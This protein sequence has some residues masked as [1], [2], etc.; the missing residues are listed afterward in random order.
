MDAKFLQNVFKKDDDATVTQIGGS[1]FVETTM[2]VA[3]PPPPPPLTDDFL[4]EDA[5]TAPRPD[6]RIQLVCNIFIVNSVVTLVWI[7]I[8]LPFFSWG[9]FARIVLIA[10]CVLQLAFYLAFVFMREF[11]QPPV[12]ICIVWLCWVVTM[13]IAFG[14]VTSLLGNVAPLQLEAMLWVQSL[15]VI[16][17][18]KRSPREI[19]APT[20]FLCMCIGTMVVWAVCVAEFVVEHDWTSGTV[21][22]VVAI[23][24]ALYSAHGIRE[25]EVHQY[26]ASWDDLLAA[27]VQFYGEPVIQ[28]LR[29]IRPLNA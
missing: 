26:N 18:T 29:K 27:I 1:V 2:P 6:V 13:G 16:V 7:A 5:A 10:A 3:R 19:S 21:I 12:A 4:L 24:C 22:L 20:A 25:S 11:K 23:F 17:Y 28:L 8:T 14:A 15:V 9:G